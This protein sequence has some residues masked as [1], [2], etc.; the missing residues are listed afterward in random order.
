MKIYGRVHIL[1]GKAVRLPQGDLSEVISLDADPIERA[2]GW[3]RKGCERVLVTDLDAAINNDGRNQDL[4]LQLVGEVEARVTVTG[5]AR[6]KAHVGTLIDAG[7]WRVGIG[8]QALLDQ[9][10]T[11]EMCRLYPG[12]IVVAFDIDEDEKIWVHGRTLKTEI[13]L[14]DALLQMQASGAAGYFLAEVGRDALSEGPNLEA[15]EIALRIVDVPVVAAGGVRD[16]DDL[17]RL[18][19]LNPDGD[20]RL[21]GVIVGREVTAGRFTIE[22]AINAVH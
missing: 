12:R 18:D 13:E 8:T 11:Y 9:T 7:A 3:V 14:E 21:D 16:L 6:S 4:L 19:E 20:H 1:D 10:F 22:E 5:G 17:R 2:K 15:L